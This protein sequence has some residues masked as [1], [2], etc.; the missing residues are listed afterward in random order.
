M[1]GL[2]TTTLYGLIVLVSSRLIDLDYVESVPDPTYT[3]IADQRAQVVSYDQD[4]AIASDVAEV[5]QSLILDSGE[6]A[7]KI[8]YF[9]IQTRWKPCQDL[10]HLD[11]NANAYN[12]VLN[13]AE[14]F[15]A[16]ENLASQALHACF[17]TYFERSP[18]KVSQLRLSMPTTIEACSVLTAPVKHGEKSG[19]ILEAAAAVYRQ[20]VDNATV[21]GSTPAMIIIPAE[22]LDALASSAGISQLIGSESD[23][24]TPVSPTDSSAAVTPTSIP[25]STTPAST[26]GLVKCTVATPQTSAE[27]GSQEISSAC[28]SI[29]STVTPT[30]TVRAQATEMAYNNCAQYPTTC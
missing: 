5:L 3:I 4:A 22:Q 12:V 16:D 7:L 17:N 29:I 13:L 26:T 30:V 15:V 24:T 10:D 23:P 14:N 6:D 8:H 27:R 11:D 28:S 9:D 19:A 18:N 1:L 25:S 21:T 20:K 2:T